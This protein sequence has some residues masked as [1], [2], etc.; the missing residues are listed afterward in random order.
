M[1][2]PHSRPFEE[3][4]QFMLHESLIPM[5]RKLRNGLPTVSGVA[6]SRS[7]RQHGVKHKGDDDGLF[8]VVWS[9][10]DS[11]GPVPTVHA[12]RRPLQELRGQ[13]E[14]MIFD[15]LGPDSKRMPGEGCHQS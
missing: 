6:K 14:A 7:I 15:L 5:L 1:L 9:G 8:G 13:S 2:S 10:G 11:R 3:K 12:F 4:A